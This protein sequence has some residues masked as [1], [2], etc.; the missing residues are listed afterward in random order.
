MAS[1][2]GINPRKLCYRPIALPASPDLAQVQIRH[3]KMGRDKE[4]IPQRK[5]AHE[6]G[7]NRKKDGADDC[8]SNVIPG[9][10]A[11]KSL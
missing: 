11:S 5:N 3:E 1:Q 7:I 2:G 4:W 6:K 8:G 9:Y 10:E